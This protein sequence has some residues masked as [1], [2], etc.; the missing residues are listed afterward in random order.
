[1]KEG[2]GTRRL[3]HPHRPVNQGAQP[4]LCPALGRWAHAVTT[5]PPPDGP[6]KPQAV[7]SPDPVSS[8][9][10]SVTVA[11]H[12]GGTTALGAVPR[13]TRAL[14]APP[15]QRGCGKDMV[16]SATRCLAPRA[17]M[18]SAVP[19]CGHL[20]PSSCSWPTVTSTPLSTLAARTGAMQQRLGDEDKG[21][22]SGRAGPP[23]LAA[24]HARLS[25]AAF[26]WGNRE[27]GAPRRE[28]LEEPP[29]MTGRPP[30]SRVPS[31]P[32]PPPG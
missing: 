27:P 32:A 6:L 22:C 12:S 18:T 17:L 3:L 31:L 11:Q 4:H 5:P 1:M 2:W 13:P 8:G 26:R 16:T 9:P 19:A 25:A 7:S 30:R 29:V 20:P 28:G 14:E 10:A 15:V 23:G 24:G 21:L